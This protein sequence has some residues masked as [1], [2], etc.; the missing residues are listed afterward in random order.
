M[1]ILK[2]LVSSVRDAY[3]L[4]L[5]ISRKKR[6]EKMPSLCEVAANVDVHFE[7]KAVGAHTQRPLKVSSLL[8]CLFADQCACISLM[9]LRLLSLHS[10]DSGTDTKSTRRRNILLSNRLSMPIFS[11][12]YSIFFEQS[13]VS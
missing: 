5:I 11:L 8:L 13:Y 10:C 3:L 4:I 7:S 6:R 12:I 1:A 9:N 2:S